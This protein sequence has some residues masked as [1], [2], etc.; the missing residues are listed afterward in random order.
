VEGNVRELENVLERAIV[1]G[2]NDLISLRDLSAE[3][4]TAQGAT[5][6]DLRGRS[7]DSSV[8]T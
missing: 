8:S 7:G 5:P 2:G 1:L 6:Q 3:P 4:A